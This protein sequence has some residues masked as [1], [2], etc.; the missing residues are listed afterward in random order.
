MLF[1]SKEIA[2]KSLD[3]SR[4]D[5]QSDDDQS[6]DDQSDE[7]NEADSDQE[8]SPEKSVDKEEKKEGDNRAPRFGRR[9]RRASSS[10]VL[11]PGGSV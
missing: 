5:D 1:R 10:G 11:T 2:P 9:R 3:T 6:D 8:I 4:D 7:K